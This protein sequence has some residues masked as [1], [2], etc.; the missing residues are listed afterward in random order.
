MT[1][2]ELFRTQFAELFRTY[3]EATR[4]P[5]TVVSQVVAGYHSFYLNCA[6]TDFAAGKFDTILARF[7]AI[8]PADLPWPEGIERP[9]PA[10]LS[11]EA[12]QL[13]DGRA[14]AGVSDWPADQPWPADIPRPV[15]SSQ[16][17]GGQG[18][19]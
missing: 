8:W 12:I 4:T 16:A 3:V 18:A 7:S 17:V 1:Y 9:A 13:L 10:E 6:R 15:A 5:K 2:L 14:R 19:Q 11:D